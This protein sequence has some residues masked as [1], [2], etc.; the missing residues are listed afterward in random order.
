MAVGK[1]IG[2]FSLKGT[3]FPIAPGPGKALTLQG[4][5]E[6]PITGEAGEGYGVGT[7]TLVTEPGA[8]GGTW[9]WSG[10]TYLSSGGGIGINSQ[11]TWQESGV[12]KWRFHGTGEDST[13]RLIDVEAEADLATRTLAGKLYEWS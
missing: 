2:E 3:S 4:N 7:L 9:T 10:L 13:G 5:F 6:G 1:Q 11:G 8:K 12:N